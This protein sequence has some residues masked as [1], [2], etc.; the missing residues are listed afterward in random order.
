[1]FCIG[2]NGKLAINDAKRCMIT[3]DTETEGT[4]R[5]NL[6]LFGLKCADLDIWSGPMH[7]PDPQFHK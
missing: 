1:M 6:W 4:E 7:G 5:E 3:G 2:R